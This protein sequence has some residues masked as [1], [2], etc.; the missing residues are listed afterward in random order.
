MKVAFIVIGVLVIAIP[1]IIIILVIKW[2]IR[3]KKHNKN[4]D[5]D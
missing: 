3:K 5:F 2:L 4:T 1:I